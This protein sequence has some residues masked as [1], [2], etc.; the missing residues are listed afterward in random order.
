[1][2]T[3]YDSLLKKLQE[4]YGRTKGREKAR[5]II[6]EALASALKGWKAPMVDLRVLDVEVPDL[7][8]RLHTRNDVSPHV[9]QAH[10]KS[11]KPNVKR[12]KVN[13]HNTG[14]RDLKRPTTTVPAPKKKQMKKAPAPPKHAQSKAGRQKASPKRTLKSPNSKRRLRQS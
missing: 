9:K 12:S 13:S 14:A 11:L 2:M 10:Q 5:E 4:P 1:M 3:P 8:K 7:T 6:R